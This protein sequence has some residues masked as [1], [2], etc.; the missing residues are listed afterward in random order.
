MPTILVTGSFDNFHSQ[1]LRFLQEAAKLGEVHVH[2]WPDNPANPTKFPFAERRYLLESTRYVT[3]VSEKIPEADI[4]VVD[5][6]DDTA[7]N[8]ELSHARGVKYHVIRNSQLNGFPVPATI[9]V[10]GKKVIV[11]GCYD[12]FHSGHVR[13]FEEVAQLGNLHVVIG[14]DA[15]V[16]LLKGTGHPAFTQDERRYVVS[17]MRYVKQCLIS[18]GTGWLDAEPEMRLIKPDIYAVNDDGDRPEKR[19]YCEQHGMQYVVLKRIPKEGLSKRSSTNLR[20]F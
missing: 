14:S 4:L 6:A 10:T 15:N 12:W 2:L 5:E 3:I 8:R 9:P 11:T 7:T 17:S 18:T 13:F 19:T 16:R 20:G 1:Q